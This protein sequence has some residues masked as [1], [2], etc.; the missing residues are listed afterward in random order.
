MQGGL[1]E[2]TA[3]LASQSGLSSEIVLRLT[4]RI[5]AAKG[6]LPTDIPAWIAWTN[7]WLIEDNEACNE[8]L[9]DTKAGILTAAGR[10]QTEALDEAVF[11]QILPGIM[12]WIA[13]APLSE[14]DEILGGEPSSPETTKRTCLRARA[15]VSA[16]IPRGY[17]FV[18]GLV[19]H[20][21]KELDPFD[22]Q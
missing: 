5:N 3:I 9:G 12:S 13:G 19:A 14:I 8:L 2:T 20:V 21:V 11:R 16:V 10:T 1:D 18:L 15:L 7:E 22:D 6:T 4:Q 17:S